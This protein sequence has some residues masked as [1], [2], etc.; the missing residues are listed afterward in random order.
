MQHLPG[1]FTT[2]VP[3]LS[4]AQHKELTRKYRYRADW[5]FIVKDRGAGTVTHRRERSSPHTG[6]RSPTSSIGVTSAK[7]R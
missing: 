6:T 5:V 7:P 4:G 1:L 2:V 3:W